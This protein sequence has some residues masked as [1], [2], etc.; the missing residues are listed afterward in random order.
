[1]AVAC[2]VGMDRDKADI[3][4][5]QLLAPG[6]DAIGAGAEGDVVFFRC[7]QGGVEAPVLEVSDYCS[8]DFT[9]VF[10]LPE[11]K[12]NHLPM[13]KCEKMWDRMS[14]EEI[15]PMMPPRS[16]VASRRSWASRSA[17]R[18]ES[19]PWKTLSIEDIASLRAW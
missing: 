18:L 3:S 2:S 7:D 11:E 8:C 9:C 17:G 15:S 13:Q 5:S 4:L 10:V 1:M 14:W 16:S 19:I 6:V 12:E